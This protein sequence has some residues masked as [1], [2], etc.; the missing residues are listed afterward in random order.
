LSP[1]NAGASNRS[2]DT[3]QESKGLPLGKPKALAT[4]ASVMVEDNGLL[5]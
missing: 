3:W 4:N 5:H 2:I 1:S